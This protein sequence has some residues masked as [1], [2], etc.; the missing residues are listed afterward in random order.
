MSSQI[1]KILVQ[2]PCLLAKYLHKIKTYGEYLQMHAIF[3]DS[4][5]LILLQTLYLGKDIQ[6]EKIIEFKGT[7][8]IDIRKY[9]INGKKPRVGGISLNYGQYL[10]LKALI[11]EINQK[12]K[13]A[14]KV[15]K[16]NSTAVESNLK[17]KSKKTKTNSKKANDNVEDISDLKLEIKEEPIEMKEEPLDIK[18]EPIDIKEEPLDIK[19]EID[20]QFK[21]NSKQANDKKKAKNDST[22][23]KDLLEA[24]CGMFYLILIFAVKKYTYVLTILFHP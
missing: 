12:L 20:Y 6:L 15:K 18:K 8:L 2:N 4:S 16:A 7:T 13:R 10:K 9:I 5:Q 23:F 21:T 24:I 14:Q 11:P 22:S 3:L 19:K 1:F 17:S